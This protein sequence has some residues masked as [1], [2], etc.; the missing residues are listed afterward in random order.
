MLL[1]AYRDPSDRASGALPDVENTSPFLV[2]GACIVGYDPSA[3]VKRAD[4]LGRTALERQHP[5]PPG[6]CRPQLAPT[7][8]VPLLAG[9]DETPVTNRPKGSGYPRCA[10]AS[11]SDPGGRS[12]HSGTH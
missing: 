8:P 3:P 9:L 7:P 12:D 6:H 1:V 2:S 5:L 4:D 10:A 11:S